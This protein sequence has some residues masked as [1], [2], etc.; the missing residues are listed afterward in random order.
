M[1]CPSCGASD[2]HKTRCEACGF[3]FAQAIAAADDALSLFLGLVC[4]AC[5]T[6]NDPGTNDCVSCGAH[7]EAGDSGFDIPATPIDP[8][9]TA[10][11]APV[12]TSS[13]WSSMPAATTSPPLE[14][15]SPML[16]LPPLPLTA[17]TA[18][19][20]LPPPPAQPL[21]PPPSWMNPPTGQ[22]LATN[23]AMKKVDLASISTVPAPSLAAPITAAPAPPAPPAPLPPVPPLPRTTMTSPL[24]WRCAGPLEA[25][26]KFCRQCGART[27]S[28]DR[29]GAHSGPVVAATA[30]RA[31]SGPGGSSSPSSPVVTQMIAAFKLPNLAPTAPPTSTSTMVMPAMQLAASAPYRP[32]MASAGGPTA[33]MVF[34][35]ATVERVAKLIL[36]RGHS[37]F[38]SQWRLQ[39]GETV[40]G[41]SDGMVLFPDDMA[42]AHRH[43]RLVWRGLD[44]M[45]EPEA[46]TNGVYVRLRAPVRLQAGD[47]FLVGAQRL[48]VLSNDERPRGIDAANDG[49][50]LLGSVLKPNPPI[51][52]LKIGADDHLNEIYCRP[53]RLLTIGRAQCDINFD[54]DGFVSERHAQLTHE[55]THITLEDLGSRNGTYV[56]AR[57]AVKLAHGDLLLLGDQ[58]LRIE[59]PR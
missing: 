54:G 12:T 19:S 37:Q 57:T 53:Q 30:P 3:A 36:V 35:A 9:P 15:S 24:C 10:P 58:V 52:L 25:H 33:T 8:A 5:D 4:A 40:I 27:D 39:S 44:L 21:A 22:P 48:R 50:L 28:P 47:E 17:P 49:T 51:N 26:D 41:R 43:A 7:L 56:R 20:S 55:G 31:A 1:E 42:I 16:P 38:G 45:L 2:Q 14:L 34:G 23:L 59:L 32:A 13:T 6:Y 46:T 11:T 29:P 18:L